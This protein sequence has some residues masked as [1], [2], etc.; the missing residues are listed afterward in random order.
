MI[1]LHEARTVA[2]YVTGPGQKALMPQ[3]F[4]FTCGE[5]AFL[6]EEKEGEMQ[7]ECCLLSALGHPETGTLSS[8]PPN[9]VR[10]G[11]LGRR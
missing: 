9:Q 2:D 6:S 7:R 4:G 8:S 10:P 1:T 5:R 11:D 3:V